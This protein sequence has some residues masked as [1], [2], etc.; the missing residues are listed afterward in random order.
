MGCW[1]RRTSTRTSSATAAKS[2]PWSPTH[3]TLMATFSAN[4]LVYSAMLLI[5]SSTLSMRWLSVLSASTLMVAVRIA[6]TSRS[7]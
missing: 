7:V 1:V 2:R 4:R 3:V 5:T 6:L